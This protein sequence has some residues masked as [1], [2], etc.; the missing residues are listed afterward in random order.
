M[1]RKGGGEDDMG[2]KEGERWG[3][4]GY[5]TGPLSVLQL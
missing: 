5:P 1:K 3:S 2:G 4:F